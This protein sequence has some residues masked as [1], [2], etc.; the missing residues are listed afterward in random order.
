MS[1]I[2]APSE[3]FMPRGSDRQPPFALLVAGAWLLVVLQLVAHNW[4]A[5]GVTLN[6]T[7]DAMRLV[8]LRAFLAGK[9]WFD[10]HETRIGAPEGYDTH[11]SRLIDAGLAGLAIGFGQFVD[12]TL[13]ERLMRV[14][15]PLVWALPA[16]LAAAAIGWRI[17][18]RPAAVVT[19][20]FAVIGQP[21]FHQFIPGRIDHHNV[22]IVLA[23]AAVAAVAWADRMRW[24]AAAAGLVSGLALAIG[25]EGVPIIAVA[26]AALVLR[27][28]LVRADDGAAVASYGTALAVSAVAAFL[29]GVPPAAWSRTACDAIAVNTLAA[30]VVAGL[31]LA[32]IA[33][34]P[35]AAR[36]AW[37]WGLT[38]ALG[39]AAAVVLLAL[40]PRCAGG[41]F[42]AM[43]PRLRTIWLAHVR[44]MQPLVALMR[45]DPATGAGLAAF[46]VVAIAALAA[47]AC[48][49]DR[50]R[51]PGLLA[52]A[53]AFL[54]A[55]AMTVASVKVWSYAM[56][57]GMPVA[58]AGALRLFARLKLT[59]LPA[60]AF[61][62][63]LLAPAVV[64]SAAAAAVKAVRP[65]ELGP[66]GDADHQACFLNA[67]YAPMAGLAPGLVAAAIDYGPFILA[68]TPHAVIAGP[69]HR[70]SAAVTA[71][72][73]A[74]ASP[75]DAARRVLARLGAT[76]VAVCG[77]HQ[78]FGFTP[79]ER[80]AGL[81]GRLQAGEIPDWLEPV[82]R[83][84]GQAFGLYRIRPAAAAT[85]R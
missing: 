39:A 1:A 20:L 25:F 4:A 84:A 35:L 26:G 6:D 78:P 12:Q 24:A 19:L 66:T 49:R 56:W 85:C 5:T 52:A 23:L 48:D 38:V 22:Q 33:R 79:T 45:Q 29:V 36:P 67:S 28:L 81:W 50:R 64:S 43:D 41:P 53:A 73:D 32:A 10:L 2:E 57:F 61:V 44:E 63:L 55:L 54:L 59:S 34:A 15:W 65:A 11:W 8:E 72:H 75:P 16:I 62:A 74:F 82:P 47:E 69:Y 83:D 31:G 68:L 46:L 37:R 80:S 42:A 30:A 60:R 70:L 77:S 18:G 27:D 3:P 21:A 9:G 14:V 13:A 58:A 40:D 71:T 76:Y 17:A 51:D 7:D